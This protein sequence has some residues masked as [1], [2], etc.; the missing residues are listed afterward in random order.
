MQQGVFREIQLL[1]NST[2]FHPF[3]SLPPWQYIFFNECLCVCKVYV[4]LHICL[5]TYVQIYTHIKIC[6]YTYYMDMYYVYDS[7]FF[8]EIT[9][10]QCMEIFLILFDSCIV[11]YCKYVPQFILPI[12]CLRTF[13]LFLGFGCYACTK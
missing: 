11:L 7:V 5:H 3:L 4:Y 9:P 6:L 8:L 2:S 10:Q 12:P 1:L 13:G